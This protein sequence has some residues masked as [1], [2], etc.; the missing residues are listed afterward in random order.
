M[1]AEIVSA[2]VEIFKFEVKGATAKRLHHLPPGR[3]NLFADS[4]SRYSGDP[5]GLHD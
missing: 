5:I 4:I 2:P 3:H 1:L